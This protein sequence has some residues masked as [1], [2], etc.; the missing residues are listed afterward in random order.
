MNCT[1]LPLIDLRSE[2]DYVQRHIK[3][4][5]HLAWPSLQFRLNELPERPAKLNL[6]GSLEDIELARNFLEGKGYQI[7]TL[8]LVSEIQRLSQ[9]LPDLIEIGKQSKILWQPSPL[10]KEFITLLNDK[11]VVKPVFGL[12]IG[13][14]GGRDS[15]Y[16]ALN[17]LKMTGVDHQEKALSRAKKLSKNHSVT[18]NWLSCDIE[19]DICFPKQNQDLILV[20]RYLNRK[21]FNQIK[22]VLRPKGWLV[23]QTFSEGCE[24]LGSPKNPNFILR[25]NELSEVFSDFEIFVDRIDHLNDGRPVVSFIA[26]KRQT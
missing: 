7:Q 17:G 15:V 13:C 11:E 21:L 12:D 24:L 26:R 3:D 22:K 8:F 10:V 6:L 20:V 18:V 19:T 5:T 23:F 2:E 14:G 4:S 9:N 1:F 25:S 16:L